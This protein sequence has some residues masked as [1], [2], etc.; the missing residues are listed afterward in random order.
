MSFS[1]V[2]KAVETPLSGN[3]K[4]V[5]I[6]MANY[7]DEYD[8]CYPSQ[9][10]LARQAGLS[11]RTIQRIV[12]K[13]EELGYLLI[14][15]RGTGNKSSIYKLCFEVS[16]NQSSQNVPPDNLSG[17]QNV[18][19]SYHDTI[20]EP[21]I[22]PINNTR[23]KKSKAKSFDAEN[24]ELPDYVNRPSWVAYCKMRQDKGK[25]SAIKTADTV[26]LCL[27]NLEKFS[28]GDERLATEI[29]EQSIANSQFSR[30]MPLVNV[31]TKTRC[32]HCLREEIKSL[33]MNLADARL[34]THGE[35]VKKLKTNSGIPLRF[36]EAN[37]EGYVETAQNRYAKKLCQAYAEKWRERFKQ[38]GGLVLCGK[39]G[40]GKNHLACAIA[41]AV[42]ENH[43]ADVLLTTAMRITRKVK[44]TWDRHTEMREEDVIREYCRRDLLI[45]DEVGVQ[46][47]TEAEKIIL[48][49][50]I[51]ER[52]EQMLPTTLM[53]NLTEEELEKYIGERVLDRLRDGK[54]A[55]VKFDW[56]S[57]RR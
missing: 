12:E 14:L 34:K 44:S 5:F 23:A 26:K 3:E 32:P 17:R 13:L 38:G 7:A 31:V 49:E 21:I 22:D 19:R 15:R 2:A 52:Y 8:R 30:K 24:V 1:A 41:N 10:T 16:E 9:D 53:S 33:E 4:L 47:G 50:I 51:N 28:G 42:M 57:Y 27:R 39:P 36:A 48:F 45:I 56:E 43:E 40:T 25:G 55:V 29:L 18:T 37:F 54:G 46:F 11:I 35:K 6:L 20:N